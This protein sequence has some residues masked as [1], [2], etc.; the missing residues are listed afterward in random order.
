MIT[1][2]TRNRFTSFSPHFSHP[3]RRFSTSSFPLSRL[4][5]GADTM[6]KTLLF[7]GSCFAMHKICA[8][9]KRETSMDESFA[10]HSQEYPKWSLKHPIFIL[11]IAFPLCYLARRQYIWN[12]IMSASKNMEKVQNAT[13]AV[14]ICEEEIAKESLAILEKNSEIHKKV[15]K[16]LRSVVEYKFYTPC[17]FLPKASIIDLKHRGFVPIVKKVRT[18]QEMRDCLEQL[19]K[20]NNRI[21][22]LFFH[23]HGTPSAV[24][25]DSRLSYASDSRWANIM[26]KMSDQSYVVL[27]SCS[28]GKNIN[29]KSFALEVSKYNRN[30][31]VIAPEVEICASATILRPFVFKTTLQ[32][33]MIPTV[34]FWKV[35]EK[36]KNNEFTEESVLI[37]QDGKC[38]IKIPPIGESNK[39]DP[40]DPCSKKPTNETGAVAELHKRQKLPNIAIAA[41]AIAGMSAAIWGMRRFFKSK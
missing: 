16:V 35:P 33:E 8:S 37:F 23:A 34:R 22:F 40:K 1:F 15:H 24:Q 30:S 19:H 32:M 25:I 10:E 39:I 12:T 3:H 38:L 21:K 7:S 29:G 17:G 9:Q 27:Y 41:T 6:L 13:C 2:S 36:S 26:K 11:G 14:F 4:S 5:L 20:Q 31:F 28:V 18:L